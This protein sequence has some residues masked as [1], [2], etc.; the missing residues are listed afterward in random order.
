[1]M[2]SLSVDFNH[3][4]DEKK[5]FMSAFNLAMGNSDFINPITDNQ[6]ND[7]PHLSDFTAFNQY[8]GIA[9]EKNITTEVNMDDV[10]STPATYLPIMYFPSAIG[11]KLAILLKGSIADIY[12]AGRVFNLFT[13]IML[14]IC[15]IKILPYKKD[16]FQVIFMLPLIICIGATYS[17]D[18]T[19][20]GLVSIFIATCLR[21][22]KEK[23]ILNIK[24]VLILLGVFVLLCL[25]KTMAYVAVAIIFL[26]L[27]VIKTLK[28]NKK[29]LK[30]II[31]VC[32]IAIIGLLLLVY[33]V[34]NTKIGDDPRGG[35]TSV[36]G[37]L[38]FIMENPLKASKVGFNQIMNTLL[39][40]PWLQQI[41]TN[42]FFGKYGGQIFTIIMIFVI[43]ISVTDS[44]YHFKIKDKILF[45][46]G[47]FFSFAITSLVLYIS[48]TPVGSENIAGYQARY[49]IPVLPLLLMCISS[50][51]VE[52]TD[53]EN[54]KLMI[55]YFS[56]LMIML[57][58][59]GGIMK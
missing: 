57:S 30:Y 6:L 25:A 7:I 37:Q 24:D 31:P 21:I 27:P 8:Y 43:Y 39:S 29:Y 17:V 12:I 50:K 13:F 5:H 46:L 35:E 11:I 32:F 26:I 1:M 58:L 28:E 45:L 41:N 36:N 44:S 56:G 49:V 47:A 22:Y 19:A 14:A 55:N 42:V 38:Q 48:F 2:F 52:Y 23:K 53:L 16:I 34:K 54:R 20:L 33:Y 3:A 51:K 9:Y 59:I 10:P 40:L 15:A 18:S 4:I